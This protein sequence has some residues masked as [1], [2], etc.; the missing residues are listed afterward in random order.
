MNTSKVHFV[1]LKKKKML[2]VTHQM[3]RIGHRNRKK[4]SNNN[5]K[6]ITVSNS[7]SWDKK[8]AT[9]T[10]MELP[11]RFTKCTPLFSVGDSIFINNKKSWAKIHSHTNV[12]LAMFIYW[13]VY[14]KSSIKNS[15]IFF[16][17]V[18][19]A[20]ATECISNL[21]RHTTA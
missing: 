7:S 12:M 1:D 2:S 17:F 13:I 10:T 4:N 6:F 15:K 18:A 5:N 19:R 20:H 11:L 16:F 8:R 21:E 9:T 14:I 3:K